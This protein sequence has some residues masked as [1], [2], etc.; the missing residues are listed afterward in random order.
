MPS[1]AVHGKPTLAVDTAFDCHQQRSTAVDRMLKPNTFKVDEAFSL[2]W[3]TGS[4][5][6]RF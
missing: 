6:T 3:L 4:E 1:A 2:P 5:F